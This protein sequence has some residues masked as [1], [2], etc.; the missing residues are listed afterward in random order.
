MFLK[1]LHTVL[2]KYLD[3]NI[4]VEI[5]SAPG[6]GK[7]E[8]IDQ[9]IDALSI[10]DGFR[11]GIAKC[12]IATMTPVDINGY[13]VPGEVDVEVDGK[14][15]RQRLSE[16]TRPTWMTSTE[17]RSMNEYKRGVV[18]F[19]EWDKG[20]PDTKKASAE[21][22]LNGKA[23]TWQLHSGISRIALVNRSID[24]SGSTKNFD[25]IINRRGEITVTGEL[26]GW[27]D[28]ALR[29]GVDPLFVAFADKHP[30]VVFSNTI[31]ETQQPYC[32]PRSLVKLSQLLPQFKDSHGRLEHSPTTTEVAAGMIGVPAATKMMSWILLRN[33][34][35]D[36]DDILKDPE[37][38]EVPARPDAKLMVCYEL[39]HK[40]DKKTM[41]KVITYV[42]R[43]P[44][45]FAVTFGK[46]A[47]RRDYDMI[48]VPAM[49]NWLSKNA[50]LLNAIGGAR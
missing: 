33:E 45:E 46:A 48:N 9:I 31:P 38:C 35:P 30:D 2:P 26:S 7:S 47:T 5:G 8:S 19:E 34:S 6:T 1:D 40:V 16:F 28:W 39:A 3:A 27:N 21:P 4:P 41:P 13:L 44:A 43:F 12:F 18:V 14:K 29:T 25:F 24:R 22:I 10:R 49:A 15:V 42:R 32:T 36:W 37:N 20:D 11:W 50:S 17:G 23:G